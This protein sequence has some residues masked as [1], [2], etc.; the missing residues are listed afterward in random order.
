VAQNWFPRGW[1]TEGGVPEGAIE[2]LKSIDD[3]ELQNEVLDQVSWTWSV[4]NR[5][6]LID[7]FEGG[8]VLFSRLFSRSVLVPSAG[9]HR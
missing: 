7:Y 2:W 5:E 1:P 6:S 9:I 4:H 8:V 3:A